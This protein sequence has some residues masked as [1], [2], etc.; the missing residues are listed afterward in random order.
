MH[1]RDAP[2]GISARA[3]G[4]L[5]D[6]IALA[7]ALGASLA[8][9][10]TIA[11]RGGQYYWTDE[12]RFVLSQQAA[13][14]FA[15]GR[16]DAGMDA[17]FSNAGHMLFEVIGVVPALMQRALG[18]IVCLPAIFFGSFSVLAIY[19]VWRLVRSQ[20]GS[21]REALFACLLLAGCNCN[22]YYAR[23]VFPYDLSLCLYLGSALYGF[24]T[25]RLNG[26]RSGIFAGL[27][28][29]T[30]NAYWVFGGVVLAL[31]ALG[32]RQS[33]AGAAERC[34]LSLAGLALPIVAVLGIGLIYGHDLVRSFLGFSYW[35]AHDTGDRGTAW[36]V[37]PEYFWVSERYLAVFLGLAFAAA[38]AA[39]LGGLRD[40]RIALWL[41][42]GLLLYLGQV[43]VFDVFRTYF[44]SARYVRPLSIFLCLTGGWVL[45]KLFASGRR[46]RWATGAVLVALLAQAAANFSAPLGQMFPSE[47]QR[48][49]AASIRADSDHN[50][51]LYR[52]LA[53]G[54]FE[55]PRATAMRSRPKVV[56]LERSHPLQFL[57]YQFDDYT[58][59]LRLA[60]RSRDM[61]MQAIRL[62]PENQDGRALVSRTGGPWAPYPGGMR[63]EVLFDP[64]SLVGSQPIV[65]GGMAGSGD[66][67][68]VQFIGKDTVRLGLDHWGAGATLSRP[69]RCDMGRAHALIVTYG[70]LYPGTGDPRFEEH[71][72][73]RPLLHWLLVKLDGETVIARRMEFTPAPAASIVLFRNLIGFSTASQ[74]FTGRCMSAG[75]V[76][77]D[78]LLADLRGP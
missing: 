3:S 39:F 73:W 51:G 68:F 21:S 50:L 27:G 55:S 26:L 14:D 29:L 49:A 22:F 40:R 47:F 25:G 57:P 45:A 10:V 32:R 53:D 15:G 7:I 54:Y 62:L 6:R 70:S 12:S 5:I 34:V 28:F 72:E 48:R 69:I 63:L 76:P 42:G 35:V 78:E 11:V 20:G 46:A 64:D 37:I 17:L 2:P 44:V 74:D 38:L 4:L 60:F 61:S 59:E 31:C 58:E 33:L 77:P 43:A 71:A 19:L 30:Y 16:I 56:L 8:L 66:E 36:R 75:R 1:R 9:R 52:V 65:S 18:D 24:R 13:A 67:V 23:H 41:G